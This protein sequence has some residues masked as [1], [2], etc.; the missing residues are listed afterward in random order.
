MQQPV[1][2]RQAAINR[3]LL[4]QYALR[5]DPA[6]RHHPVALQRGTGD[7]PFLEPRAR[8]GVDPWLSTRARPVTQ[9][10]NAVLFIAVVPL[11]SR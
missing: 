5:V 9:S 4:L 10:L 1:G 8:L 11:L 6:K 3:K 2:A 7:Q